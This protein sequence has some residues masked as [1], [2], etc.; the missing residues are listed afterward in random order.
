MHDLRVEYEKENPSYDASK[1]LI[2][3]KL[4]EQKAK[5]EIERL[6]AKNK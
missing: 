3:N 2:A 4:I 6:K 1:T 5:E